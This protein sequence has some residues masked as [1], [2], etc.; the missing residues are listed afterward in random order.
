MEGGEGNFFFPKFLKLKA[1]P[2]KEQKFN[3]DPPLHIRIFFF[4]P[5]IFIFTRQMG[6]PRRYSVNYQLNKNMELTRY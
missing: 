1:P 6:I 2:L 4:D 3:D 5:P